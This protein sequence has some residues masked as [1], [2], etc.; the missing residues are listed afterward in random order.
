MVLVVLFCTRQNNDIID[1]IALFVFNLRKGSHKATLLEIFF[2]FLSHD[3]V[4]QIAL[5]IPEIDLRYFNGWCM[6]LSLCKIYAI[7]ALKFRIYGGQQLPVGVVSRTRP[8]RLQ[9]SSYRS[10]FQEKY[11]AKI[12]G[13]KGCELFLSHF[14]IDSSYS[15]ELSNNFLRIVRH[16]GT[17]VA[18]DEKTVTFFW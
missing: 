6:R 3:L 1:N 4:T 15:G 9:L 16:L 11:D 12:V 5:D 7:L 14:L 17:Y 18:G 2:K 10:Y 8:L 13:I